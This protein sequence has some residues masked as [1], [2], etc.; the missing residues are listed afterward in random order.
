MWTFDGQDVR[1]LRRAL[2]LATQARLFKRLQA[3]LLVAQGNSPREAADI[4][5]QKRWCVY[6]WLRRYARRRVP[7]DLADLPR[8]GRPKAAATVTPGR[9][10]RELARDPLKLGYMAMEWTVPLMAG[11]LRRMLGVSREELI[12]EM[13]AAFL[14]AHAYI[15][16]AVIQ[17]QVA[18]V[19]GWPTAINRAKSALPVVPAALFVTY[20]GPHC[21]CPDPSAY[22]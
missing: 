14:C 3:V 15:A 13:G 8:S 5:G 20:G 2:F 18:Y 19:E 11:H 9:L 21:S 12:A 22:V 17:N 1:R 6:K 4:T 10:R 7:Q 16:P